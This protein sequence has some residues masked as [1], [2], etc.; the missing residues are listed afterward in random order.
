[1]FA[2]LH[3][4]PWVIAGD[5]NEALLD[6]DKYG[7]GVVSI[8]R[9]LEFKECLDSCNMIDLGFS[10]PRFTWTNKREVGALI[11]ERIDR[12]FV[13]LDWCMM[14]LEARISNLT[15]CHSDH[16]LVLLESKPMNQLHLP[17]PLK[18]QICWL[19]DFSFPTIVFQAWNHSTHLGEA[20][21]KFVKD[22]SIWNKNQF[23][24][25]FMKKKRIMA[26]LNGI[27]KAMAIWSNI[28][29]IELEKML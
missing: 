7:G 8:S 2:E 22:I 9:S 13:N 28:N 11:Q 19:A 21:D 25:V 1:M 16:C 3:N 15:C 29:L 10:G 24:N 17:C 14:Y 5:F 20:I 6:E 27:K 4:M 12:F 23:R 18:F 26:K